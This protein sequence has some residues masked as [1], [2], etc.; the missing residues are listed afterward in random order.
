LEEVERRGAG[1]A[2][3]KEEKENKFSFYEARF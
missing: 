3:L 2:K 1:W